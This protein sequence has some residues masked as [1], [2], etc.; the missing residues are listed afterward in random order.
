MKKSLIILSSLLISLGSFAQSSKTKQN[1]PAQST[2][3]QVNAEVK[4]EAASTP[5]SSRFFK[6]LTDAILENASAEIDKETLGAITLNNEKLEIQSDLNSITIKFLSNLPISLFK[7][8]RVEFINGISEKIGAIESP[9]DYNK[10]LLEI[11]S[12]FNS[13]VFSQDWNKKL[14]KIWLAEIAQYK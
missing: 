14:R 13:N 4:F 5:V 2:S 10:L 11:E 12:S 3:P 9:A 7:S 6:T 1:A 8:D